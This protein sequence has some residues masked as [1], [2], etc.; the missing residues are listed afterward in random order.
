MLWPGLL[1]YTHTSS[2]FSPSCPG[3]KVGLG[4]HGPPHLPSWQ[5]QVFALHLRLHYLLLASAVVVHAMLRGHGGGGVQCCGIERHPLHVGNVAGE[6]GQA[7]AICLVWVPPVLKELLEERGLSTLWENRNLQGER[8]WQDCLARASGSLGCPP[9]PQGGRETP[10]SLTPTE[11]V[12]PW[13]Q[14]LT[15]VCLG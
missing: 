1:A 14:T 13:P 11:S 2:P 10:P 9:S 12:S 15:W 4:G 8:T 7:G 3:C 5:S 6:V